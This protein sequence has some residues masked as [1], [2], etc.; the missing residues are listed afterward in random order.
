LLPVSITQTENKGDRALNA[1]DFRPLQD[2]GLEDPNRN[3]PYRCRMRTNYGWEAQ[4]SY[5]YV[6]Q[7]ISRDFLPC[8]G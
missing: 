4:I 7:K 3:R 2:Q 5:V 1:S 8:P 6:V